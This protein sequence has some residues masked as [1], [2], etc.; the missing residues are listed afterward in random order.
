MRN[1]DTGE[2]FL[3]WNEVY[4][5]RGRLYGGLKSGVFR[6][7]RNKSSK[8]RGF[9]PEHFGTNIKAFGQKF[10]VSKPKT[11]HRGGVLGCD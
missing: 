9:S 11:F 6:D 5:N 4:I 8:E 7:P 3:I 1:S 10:R 2:N